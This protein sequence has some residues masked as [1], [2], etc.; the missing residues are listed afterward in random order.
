MVVV[1]ITAMI[2]KVESSKRKKRN[3]K[4][5]AKLASFFCL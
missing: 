2:L 3:K 5:E 1:E 4:K